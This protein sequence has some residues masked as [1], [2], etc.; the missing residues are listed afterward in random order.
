MT[1]AFRIVPEQFATDAL[2]GIY[3]ARFPQRWNPPGAP[4][5]YVA[6][7]LSLALV[8]MLAQRTPPQRF[9]Y[10]EFTLHD[11]FYDPP[12]LPDDW[13]VYPHPPSTQEL[14]RNWLDNHPETILR[15][16]SVVVP[17]EYNYVLNVN[18]RYF[19]ELIAGLTPKPLSLDPRLS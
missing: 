16:P 10:F 8:E 17:I 2:T 5:L 6:E 3:S 14:A 11:I 9:V 7:H 1:R 13:T 4:V 15:V 18:A 12:S 19:Q